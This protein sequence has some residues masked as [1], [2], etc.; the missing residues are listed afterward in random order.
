[1]L[2]GDRDLAPFPAL[3][4]LVQVRQHDVPERRRQREVREQPIE[5]ALRRG[6]VEVVQRAAQRTCELVQ[7]GAASLVR[8]EPDAA[9]LGAE[10]RFGDRGPRRLRCRQ[11]LG[12]VEL[13]AANA[14]FVGAGVEPKPAR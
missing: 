10:V 4:Q 11:S 13:H 5:Y 9:R 3:T 12:E 2:L 7:F 6:F 14:V 8:T 1:M